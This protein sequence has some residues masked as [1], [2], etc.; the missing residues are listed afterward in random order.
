MTPIEFCIFDIILN[1]WLILIF[2]DY[3]L[4]KMSLSLQKNGCVPFCVPFCGQFTTPK[5][6]DN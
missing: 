1:F 2:I 3:K 6:L 4:S 5:S